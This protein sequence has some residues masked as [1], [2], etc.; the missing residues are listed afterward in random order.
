MKKREPC[1][2][3]E[4]RRRDTGK[5]CSCCYAKR[6][7]GGKHDGE[8][9]C[10]DTYMG[11]QGFV[12]GIRERWIEMYITGSNTSVSSR[13]NLVTVA[14]LRMCAPHILNPAGTLLLADGQGLIGETNK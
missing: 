4:H 5:L 14:E 7:L 10:G 9:R 11:I 3:C 12:W 8:V 2:I 6:K 13:I 1:V